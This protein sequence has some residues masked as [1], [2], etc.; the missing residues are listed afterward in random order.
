MATLYPFFRLLW[1]RGVAWDL[2]LSGVLVAGTAV[3]VA[4]LGGVL[5]E[6]MPGASHGGFAPVAV[7]YLSALLIGGAVGLTA[8]FAIQD[9]LYCKFSWLLPSLRRSLRWGLLIT[10]SACALVAATVSISIGS[11]LG[12]FAS[13]GVAAAGF[14]LGNHIWD[15]DAGRGPCFGVMAISALA[16]FLTSQ[17]APWIVAH[18][19]MATLVGV[20]TCAVSIHHTTT[21]RAARS[22]GAVASDDLGVSFRPPEESWPLRAAKIRPAA[23]ERSWSGGQI[24]STS[25]W[26]AAMR[27]EVTGWARGSWL[28]LVA[29]QVGYMLLI[30]SA[31]N[32]AM[33]FLE[34]RSV[35]GAFGWAYLGLVDSHGALAGIEGR[36]GVDLVGMMIALVALIVA[37][38]FGVDLCEG[39]LYPLSRSRRAEVVWR[40]SLHK[41]LALLVML[42]ACLALAIPLLAY[43]AG[44]ELGLQT[45]PFSVIALMVSVATLPLLQGALLRML[46]GSTGHPIAFGASLLS[47]FVLNL[48]LT[49]S[50]HGSDPLLLGVGFVLV[51]AIGHG[52]FRWLLARW[53]ATADLI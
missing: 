42:G 36:P 12:A 10:A 21:V 46:H 6:E 45:F 16:L 15:R 22:R 49:R 14:G 51:F 26:V 9:L 11:E 3:L 23:E 20:V 1:R 24:A 38:A 37:I 5:L 7:A 13:A 52:L 30:P 47:Y 48:L 17:L 31:L 33:G 39:G 32:F 35:R 25:S 27:Y 41:G 19:V 50:L 53:Y 44:V 18:P 2:A 8:N 43:A 4:G 29:R 28:R 34:T 40:A